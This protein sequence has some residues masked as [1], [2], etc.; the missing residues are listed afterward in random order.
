M[1]RQAKNQPLP[2]VTAMMLNER[3]LRLRVSAVIF[4][5]EYP[6]RLVSGLKSSKHMKVQLHR[7][8]CVQG[9]VFAKAFMRAHEK[10]QC[11]I[12]GAAQH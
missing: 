8:I 5:I 4:E 2:Q 9:V 6:D 10:H 12:A 11:M 3:M 7:H 1:Y